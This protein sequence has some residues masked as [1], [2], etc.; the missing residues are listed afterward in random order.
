MQSASQ[1][2][3]R[4]SRGDGGRLGLHLTQRRVLKCLS[5]LLQTLNAL[6]G[7]EVRWQHVCVALARLTLLRVASVGRLL[8]RLQKRLTP[9]IVDSLW[10]R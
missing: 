3:L 10:L 4:I 6:E 7:V 1:I 9:R 2:A 5:R 8:R